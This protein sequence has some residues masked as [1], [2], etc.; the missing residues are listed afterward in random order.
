MKKL[1]LLITIASGMGSII[2]Q[3]DY[4]WYKGKKV[5]LTKNESKKYVLVEK[6]DNQRT[7]LKNSDAKIIAKGEDRSNVSTSSL[8]RS[9]LKKRE[10]YLLEADHPLVA[11]ASNSSVIYEAPYYVTSSNGEAPLSHVF[12]VKL[13]K[14]DDLKQLEKLASKYGVEIAHQNAFMPEWY[15]LSAN[16]NS[17]GNA[18]T[19][20]NAFYESGLFEAAEPGFVPQSNANCTPDPYFSSQWAL[21]NTGQQNGTPG[22]DIKACEAWAITKGSSSIT[23]AVMD[24]GV[25][26]NHPDLTN[27]SPFQYDAHTGTSPNVVRGPHGTA[28]AG[29]IA[30]NHNSIGAS[31]IAPNVKIMPISVMF[32]AGTTPEGF[33]DGINYA[34]QNGAAI[35]SNSWGYSGSGFSFAI[36]DNAITNAL[37]Q[38]RGGKGTLI[39]FSTGNNNS[40]VN[41]PATAH[42]DVIAVGA[43][44]PC[45]TR[46]STTSC[47]N[48]NWPGGGG[49]YGTALDITAPGV[50]VPTTDLTGFDGYNN[51]GDYALTFNG[52]SAAAPHVAG[53]AALILSVNPNLTQKQVAD[54]I[55]KSAQKTGGYSYSTTSGRVNGTWNNEMGYGFLNAKAALD[56]AQQGTTNY[57]TKFSVPRATALPG[58]FGH[59]S[60]VHV[61]GTGGPN[62]GNVF[63][64]IFNWNSSNNAVYQFTLETN[65]GQPRHYTDL[66]G[67]STFNLN[68]AQPRITINGSTGFAGLAGTY[69]VNTHNGNNLVLVAQSGNYAL[70]FSNSSTPPNVRVEDLAAGME[71]STANSAVYPNP[72]KSEA[73]LNVK[74]ASTVI[75]SGIN[76][77]VMESFETQGEV[78]LGQQYAPGVYVVKVVS[79]NTVEMHTIV[80]Q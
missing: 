40:S 68:G 30:E 73:Q 23:V 33:A 66:V 24:E 56:L 16:K 19:I 54:I 69:Y 26:I 41:Y 55:E 5:S 28:C 78:T 70:Y 47:D 53:V 74:E 17:K 62:L 52:T 6:S 35:V 36:L 64:S 51:F 10:F 1:I 61:L 67:Y 9:S 34:W 8:E 20:A 42:P 22:I 45:G 59:Y 71:E 21:K 46:K 4:Y 79:G 72:F 80:K 31:G 25:Q 13:K 44:T 57:L 38:G 12:Y 18:L 14:A 15:T 48:E 63:N 29:I 43:G 75:V 27:I 65:N 50:F 11:E 32:G 76:G 3:S 2:A 37:T 49:N 60:K 39:V 77:N 7:S 58:M